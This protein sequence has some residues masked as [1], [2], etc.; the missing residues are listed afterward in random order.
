MITGCSAG[1]GIE[2]A[3]A[4]HATGAK[5]FLTVRNREKGEAVVRDILKTSQ[6][7]GA[8]ELLLM[9]LGALSSIRVAAADFLARSD[10]LNV[11]IANAGL[12]L[13]S[14]S[15][16]PQGLKMVIGTNHFGHFLFFQLLKLTLIESSTATFQSRVVIVSSSGHRVSPIRFP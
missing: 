15:R 14:K 6:G 13:P 3:R 4:L 11:L 1:L 12:I 8:I 2:T 10:K 9:D 16:T 5:L 7:Q